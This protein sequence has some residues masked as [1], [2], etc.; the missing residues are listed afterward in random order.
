L[1][2]LA[3]ACV[4]FA[5]V[6]TGTFVG[7]LVA[8]ALP[9]HHVSGD[10]KDAVKQGL[11]LIATLTALVLGLLVATTKGTFD[12]QSTAV[13]EMAANL[14]L[15]DRV[16][17]RYGSETKD[18]RSETKETRELIPRVVR[19]ILQQMWPENNG[20]A[21]NLTA[22]EVRV[23]GE[24]LFDRI[25]ALKPETDTQRLLKSRALEIAISLAQT[26]Q[27]LLAQKESS[28]PVPF[29]VVLGFWLTVLFGCYGLLA[30]RNLTVIMILIVCMLSVSGA[31]FLVLEMD[32]PFEGI[33]RVP[34]APLRAVLDR[35][36][37]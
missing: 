5:C 21:A 32:R 27:R 6:L 29:L 18:T 3:I 20:Q 11:A 17:D 23:A 34:S 22:D 24:A 16:L 1:S 35:L 25:S 7:M 12:S 15:L 30:P 10:S 2:S 36:G 28:I 26:R 37:E 9:E 14:V 4:V 8:R 33:V 19:V 31:L 13:K